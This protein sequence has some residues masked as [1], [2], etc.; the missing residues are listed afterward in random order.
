MI[1]F[2]QISTLLLLL[3][4]FVAQS[5][6]PPTHEHGG[7]YISR[8]AAT[9]LFAEISEAKLKQELAAYLKKRQEAS[10]DEAAKA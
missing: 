5:F 10:A 3:H 6:S 8:H 2:Y 7:K 4:A 1:H 9:K